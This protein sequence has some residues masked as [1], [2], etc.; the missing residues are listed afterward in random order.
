MK[1]KNRKCVYA[2]SFDPLTN[3]H[4]W[5]IQE[6]A[7]LFDELVVAIGVNPQKKCNYPLEARL[8]MMMDALR[9][10]DNVTVT[11]FSGQF[12]VDFATTQGADF[13]LRGVRGETDFEYERGMRHINDKI[14]PHLCTV[15]LMPP[16]HL[17]ETSSSIVRSL[18]GP[19][20]W[21]HIVKQFL[22]KTVFDTALQ[23]ELK[24]QFISIS[25]NVNSTSIDVLYSDIAAKY[26]EGHRAYHNLTHIAECLAEL[27]T[28][29]ISKDDRSNIEFAIWFHDIIYNPKS[30]SNEDDSAEFFLSQASMLGLSNERASKIANYIRA[31]KQHEPTSH[32]D[33]ALRYFLDIDLSI[34]G[35]EDSRFLEYD[36]A[37]RAE[38]SWVPGLIYSPKRKKVL[39]TFLER[40][41]IFQTVEFQNRYESRARANLQKV[42]D[43]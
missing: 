17:S 20:G 26:S 39:R 41:P 42:I 1:A 15:F 43:S 3:G 4:F 14:N 27:Q 31:T 34:L 35:A 18:I 28:I 11:F 25:S 10:I 22:P 7:R 12:L 9:G 32:N 37:I 24:R 29:E 2:G 21:T 36:S 5:M 23:F 13:I 38:F 30:K 19:P 6:G 16:K 33:Q 40:A 8:Q